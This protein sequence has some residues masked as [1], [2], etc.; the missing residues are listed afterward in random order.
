MKV[1]EKGAIE[2]EKR[3]AVSRQS[4]KMTFGLDSQLGFSE[5]FS[6]LSSVFK[7]K[8]HSILY[9]LER[10][11]RH[12]PVKPTNS[13]KNPGRRHTSWIR[14]MESRHNLNSYHTGPPDSRCTES[15]ASFCGGKDKG[16]FNLEHN[17]TRRIRKRKLKMAYFWQGTYYLYPAT[18]SR[19]SLRKNQANSGA[20]EALYEVVKDL[21][22]KKVNAKDTFFTF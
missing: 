9:R 1:S 6:D 2:V 11:A 16:P 13:A 7:G 10:P 19:V 17:K 15:E 12:E 20:K 4:Q 3:D 21:S 22:N 18:F 5:G 8:E 14:E